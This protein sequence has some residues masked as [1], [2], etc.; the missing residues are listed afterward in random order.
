M[1][2]YTC[3]VNVFILLFDKLATDEMQCLFNVVKTFMIIFVYIEFGKFGTMLPKE[4]P[5][6]SDR[7][8]FTLAVQQLSLKSHHFIKTTPL[9]FAFHN[10]VNE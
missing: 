10:N 2:K 1:N 3:N 5:K 4:L 8:N 6:G 7:Q 9:L